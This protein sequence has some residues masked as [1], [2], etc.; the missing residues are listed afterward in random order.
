MFLSFFSPQDYN[1]K[2]E[3]L[4]YSLLN[5]QLQQRPWH[6]TGIKFTES[7]SNIENHLAAFLASSPHLLSIFRH[8][9]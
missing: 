6:I 8:G 2:T 5:T 1:L 7:E 3:A 9:L 4:S